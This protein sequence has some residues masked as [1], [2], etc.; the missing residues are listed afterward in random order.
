MSAALT[1]TPVPV[2]PRRDGWTPERQG[3]FVAALAQS[4]C[5]VAAAR[6]VGKSWQT[7][8]RLRARPDATSFAAAW[9]RALAPDL[10]R[11]FSGRAMNGIATPITYRGRQVGE[12][13]RYDNRLAMYL[14]GIRRPDRP[15]ARGRPQ[16]VTADLAAGLAPC[17]KGGSRADVA[18]TSSPSA[19]LAATGKSAKYRKCRQLRQLSAAPMRTGVDGR[20]VPP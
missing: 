2:R 11:P 17:G 15:A 18:R 3:A 12:R 16:A 6:A 4:R 8:Y 10:D 20:G 5:V 14:L 19:H 1:F 7:A 9:D 13:R